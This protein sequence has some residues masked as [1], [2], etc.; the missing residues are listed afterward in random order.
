MAVEN[1][2]IVY[3]F[4]VPH[5][6]SPRDLKRCL[7]SIPHRDD[8][9]VIVVDDNSDPDVVAVIRDYEALFSNSCFIFSKK[10]GGAG[11]ARNLGLKRAIGK[12]IVFADADDYFHPCINDALDQYSDSLVDIVFFKGDSIDADTGQ[13]SF[14]THHL[15]TAFEKAA[16]S[17]DFTQLLFFSA[18][19]MRLISRDVIIKNDIQFNETQWAN[20][21]VFCAKL[22]ASSS[23]YALSPL[24]IYCL[25]KSSNSLT[26]N[27]S[28]ESQIVRLI[29]NLSAAEIYR[30]F[31]P[32]DL[33][34]SDLFQ[35]WKM[36]YK[37]RKVKAIAVLPKVIRCCRWNFVKE[38]YKLR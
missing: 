10:N 33:I 15:N 34:A 3:S 19:Y 17:G 29:E 13:P 35:R 37:C 21:V 18:V 23:S 1:N 14:R 2:S 9:Q 27:M 7:D 6:N 11:Y 4:I 32:T 16:E 28:C 30:K 24:C 22:A 8:V 31:V 36:I 12:W 5:Y 26:C 25:T 38:L 20:D